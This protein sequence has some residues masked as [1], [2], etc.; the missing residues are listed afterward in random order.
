MVTSNGDERRCS[1]HIRNLTG[2][3]SRKTECEAGLVLKLWMIYVSDYRKRVGLRKMQ[4]TDLVFGNP[5][6][7][8]PYP[9]SQLS[10]Y[11]RGVLRNVGMDGNGYTIR[12]CR[13]F[14]AIRW[15]AYGYAPYLISKNLGHT[16]A[17][18]RKNYERLSE[19]DLMA[20][21]FGDKRG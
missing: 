20:E 8:K 11:F 18:L 6:T 10:R 19:E 1:L 4:M 3:G 16:E 13:S 12:S 14:C 9:Y 7:D 2:K 21:F 17:V 15:L 5:G